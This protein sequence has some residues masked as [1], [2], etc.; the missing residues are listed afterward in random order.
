MP[1][2]QFLLATD[3]NFF[4]YKKNIY[5]FNHRFY[6]LPTSRVKK[7]NEMCMSIISKN[8]LPL[9]VWVFAERILPINIA[10]LSASELHLDD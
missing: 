8:I 2:F 1:W 3:I 10:A 4:K 9:P 7:E 6:I 5:I